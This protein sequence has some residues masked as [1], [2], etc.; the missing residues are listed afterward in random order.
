MPTQGKA[1]KIAVPKKDARGRRDKCG[2]K[3]RNMLVRELNKLFR[4]RPDPN[5][6]A[7]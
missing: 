5:A 2:N 3:I 7:S 4:R 1:K 6:H